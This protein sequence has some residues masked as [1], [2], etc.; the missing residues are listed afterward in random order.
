MLIT[1]ITVMYLYNED[2]NLNMT[3]DISKQTEPK[4]LNDS[5]W[6]VW[7]ILSTV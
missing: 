7:A 3:I 5:N 1:W 2:L 6:S 4:Y